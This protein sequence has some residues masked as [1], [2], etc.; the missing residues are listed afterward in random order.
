MAASKRYSRRLRVGGIGEAFGNNVEAHEYMDGVQHI[1]TGEV[2]DE[3]VV[4]LRFHAEKELK[5]IADLKKFQ[6]IFAKVEFEMAAI[7]CI[8][9]TETRD[10]SYVRVESVGSGQDDSSWEP[11]TTY[12]KES[13]TW[14]NLSCVSRGR[15]CTVMSG[16]QNGVGRKMRFERI[17]FLS[18]MV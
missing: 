14:R 12:W 16:F 8:C 3:H 6:Y 11:V 10:G 17:N 4:R 9:Y 1:V 18:G 7:V 5:I 13:R 15:Q 2:Q